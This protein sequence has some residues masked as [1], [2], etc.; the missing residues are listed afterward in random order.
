MADDLFGTFDASR[1]T[2]DHIPGARFIGYASGG[3]MAIGHREKAVFAIGS[4]L[5]SAGN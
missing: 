2:A 1:Y 4:F 5:K 3:H